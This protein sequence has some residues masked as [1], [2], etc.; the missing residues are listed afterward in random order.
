MR[1]GGGVEGMASRVI[2]NQSG[3]PFSLQNRIDV[4]ALV[5]NA[6]LM[7]QAQQAQQ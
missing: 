3:V 7:K 4:S 6:E 5:E 1:S 2:V